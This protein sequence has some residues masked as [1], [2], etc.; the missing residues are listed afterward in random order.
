[1]QRSWTEVER[2]AVH[3]HFCNFIAQRRVPGKDHCIRCI[4]KEKVS[5]E[6]TWVQVKNFVK[7]TI[8]ALKRESALT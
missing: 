1:M 3:N 4:R 7:N 2:R 5:S 6:R 8:I